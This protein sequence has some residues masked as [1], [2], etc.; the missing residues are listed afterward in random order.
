MRLVR[1]GRRA[2]WDVIALAED[3]GRSVWGELEA[4]DPGYKHAET[5]R[6]LISTHVPRNGPPVHNH[7]R[8]SSLGDDIFEFK[9]GPKRGKKLRVLWFYDEGRLIVCTHSFLKDTRTTPPD[10]KAKAIRMRRAYF[11]AKRHQV[12]PQ[13]E[14]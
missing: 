9:T 2:V 11:D 14:D 6:V 8:C 10:E 5:M 1:L 13:I 4:I 3:D 12:L 7:L